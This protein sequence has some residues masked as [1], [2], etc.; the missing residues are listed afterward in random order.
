MNEN[1]N[2]NQNNSVIPNNLINNNQNTTIPNNFISNNQ[3]ANN[4]MNNVVNPTL[5]ANQVQPTIQNNNVN[6]AQ[7]NSGVPIQN[8]NMINQNAT[9]TNNNGPITL[10]TV[11]NV[12]YADTIGNVNSQVA[13]TVQ[14]TITNYENNNNQFINNNS[15]NETSLTDL[16]VDGTYNNLE[17]QEK[18][19]V[20]YMND[21]QVQA[22]LN[23]QQKKTVTITKELKTV[24]ILVLILFA[25]VFIMPTLA[26]YFNKLR[27]R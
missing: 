21:P 24:I 26:D 3:N 2:F 18:T 25:F 6:P 27:F 1:Q 13:D 16:N 14:T 11:S 23:K 5:N 7:I 8:V 19:P 17:K 15:Y 12:T 4:N 20:D 9:N 10:G 22:N